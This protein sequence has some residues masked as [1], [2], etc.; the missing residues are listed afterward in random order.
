MGY[1]HRLIGDHIHRVFPSALPVSTICL[2]LIAV[3]ICFCHG[4]ATANRVLC[5]S[6][7]QHPNFVRGAQRTVGATDARDHESRDN[8]DP[9]RIA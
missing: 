7:V 9:P 4:K 5:E 1:S 6:P 8:V 2:W 3:L